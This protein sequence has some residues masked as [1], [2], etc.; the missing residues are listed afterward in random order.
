MRLDRT[1]WGKNKK[2]EK[3]IFRIRIKGTGERSI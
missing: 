1:Q 2:Y 3:N